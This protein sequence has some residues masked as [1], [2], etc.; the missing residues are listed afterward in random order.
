MKVLIWFLCFFANALITMLFKLNGVILGAIPTAI[1]LAG[2]I[3]L[4]RTLCK[5]WDEYKESKVAE[6]S[7]PIQKPQS[8]LGYQGG[9]SNSVNRSIP[10]E[11]QCSCGRT[12][13]RYETSC[14]CGKSKFD[15]ITPPKS[16]KPTVELPQTTDKIF[17]CRKCGEKL[18]D[19][20]KFCRK[21]GTEIVEA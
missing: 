7:A 21:C 6:Q 1:L 19:S 12:H 9:T 2:A 8:G 3:W 18:I 15:N 4:S 17:F 10:L 16:D 14:R 13:P 20:S 11:W 5:R